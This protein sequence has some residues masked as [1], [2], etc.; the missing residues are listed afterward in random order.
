MIAE[1]PR[2][3]ELAIDQR[4]ELHPRFQTLAEGV[5]EFT[6]ANI[7]LFRNAHGYRI[8]R[9]GAGHGPE[10]L[11]VV[12]GNDDGKSF[13][14]LPFGLPQRSLLEELFERFGSMKAVPESQAAALKG[15]GYDTIEDRDSFDYLY[16]KSDLAALQGRA[17]HKKKNLVNAFINNYTYVGKPLLEEYK[18][19]ALDV[20]D[21]W[22]AQQSAEGD[23]TAAREALEMSETLSLC[24]GVYYVDGK[25]AGY[26]LGEEVSGGT[27]YLIHFEKAVPGFKG[28]Y[29]FINMSFAGILPDKYVYL[30]REQDLGDEGLRQAKLSYRP[31]AFVKKSRAHKP[32]AH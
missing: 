15:M 10:E 16:L 1:Y 17:F 4:P 23:Y 30:N 14:M 8:S 31:H 28:L 27:T 18:P 25:P 29:Q 32:A 5:S 20:L 6:F 3:S 26:T 7:Y 13:F 24:G 22:R 19:H 11:Y 21:S 2:F 12:A 9:F